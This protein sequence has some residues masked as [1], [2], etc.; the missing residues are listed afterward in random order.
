MSWVYL[1]D[2]EVNMAALSEPLKRKEKEVTQDLLPE[3]SRVRYDEEYLK[4]LNWYNIENVRPCNII[5]VS[6]LTFGL[7]LSR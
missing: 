7:R 5:Y 4:F 6:F 1:V 3:K 2:I